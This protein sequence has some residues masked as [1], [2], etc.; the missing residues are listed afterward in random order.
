VLAKVGSNA[1]S[2]LSDVD[3]LVRL[4]LQP[5]ASD[6]PDW[7]LSTWIVQANSCGGQDTDGDHVAA[8]VLAAGVKF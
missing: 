3:G 8:Q 6:E 4:H 2:C 5:P 7:S 1:S